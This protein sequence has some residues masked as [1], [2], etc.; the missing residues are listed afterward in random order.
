MEPKLS[1]LAEWI[2]WLGI[3]GRKM[4]DATYVFHDRIA[5][6]VVL[7]LAVLS[8]SARSTCNF[9]SNMRCFTRCSSNM[10]RPLRLNPAIKPLYRSVLLVIMSFVLDILP[11][12]H[13]ASLNNPED[14]DWIL[15]LGCNNCLFCILHTLYRPGKQAQN[16]CIY[17]SVQISF[18]TYSTSLRGS[19]L[20]DHLRSP[21]KKM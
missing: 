3:L 20:N 19:P 2:R 7:K 15:F 6:Q 1:A 9:G 13:T 11:L 17:I 5:N 10:D 8:R 4:C 21:V 18:K 16:N 12:L 14:E